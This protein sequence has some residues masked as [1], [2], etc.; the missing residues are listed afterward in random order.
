MSADEGQVSR[1]RI[2]LGTHA[3]MHRECVEGS[4]GRSILALDAGVWF[5]I[6]LVVVLVEL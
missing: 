1:M 6:P 4:G 2:E 5:A 3:R